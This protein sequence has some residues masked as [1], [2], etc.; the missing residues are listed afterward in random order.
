MIDLMSHKGLT[1]CSIRCNI[2]SIAKIKTS[3]HLRMYACPQLHHANIPRPVSTLLWPQ[4][5]QVVLLPQA[6]H[7]A[8]SV[9]GMMEGDIGHPEEMFPMARRRMQAAPTPIRQHSP[10]ARV[11]A[12]VEVVVRAAASPARAE[13]PRVFKEAPAQHNP[14]PSNFW[15]SPALSRDAGQHVGRG[16]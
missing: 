3:K 13:E 6:S 1:N 16:R 11:I 9:D 2:S 5:S 14:V 7:P 4:T 12:T 8:S 15:Q 10:N